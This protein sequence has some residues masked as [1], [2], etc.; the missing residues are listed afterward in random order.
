MSDEGRAPSRCMIPKGDRLGNA[1]GK[2][3]KIRKAPIIGAIAFALILGVVLV[4]VQ[5]CTISD[6]IAEGR[7]YL[8]ELDNQDVDAVAKDVRAVQ[9]K[10]FNEMSADNPDAIWSQ[11]FDSMICGDS[12]VLGF[13]FFGFLPDKNVCAHS[14]AQIDELPQYYERIGQAKP[15]VIYLCFGLNDLGIRKWMDGPSYA[16]EIDSKCQDLKKA[17]PDSKICISSILPVTDVGLGADDQYSRI[18][19]YN[20]SVKEMAHSKGYIYADCT[21]MGKSHLDLYQEDGLH[22]Q[23]ELL[24]YWAE[25]LYKAVDDAERD[26]E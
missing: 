18:D 3:G 20:A 24:H 16:Q 26:S 10:I 22:L 6:P 13:S 14:G 21:E 8:Q 15:D 25:E 19:E 11:F 7:G 17:S 5:R 1:P 12:R 4:T 23:A 2:A 9:K